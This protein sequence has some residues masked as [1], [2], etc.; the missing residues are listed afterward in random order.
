M[1]TVNSED[2]VRARK[3]RKLILRLFDRQP[4]KCAVQVSLSYAAE[5]VPMIVSH[6]SEVLT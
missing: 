2:D 5:D 6:V 4:V 1:N 3:I